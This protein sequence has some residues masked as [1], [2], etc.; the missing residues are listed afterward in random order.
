MNF[1]FTQDILVYPQIYC[2]LQTPLARMMVEPQK[3]LLDGKWELN[4]PVHA[5][6]KFSS[7]VWV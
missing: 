6:G 3:G 1:P 4:L 7:Q 2:L 5:T